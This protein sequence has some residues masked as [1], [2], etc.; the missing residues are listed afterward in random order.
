MGRTREEWLLTSTA[1]Q[2]DER[3][4]F[5]LTHQ[6]ECI[7]PERLRGHLAVHNVQFAGTWRDVIFV[8]MDDVTFTPA[9]LLKSE[10]EGL[11]FRVY[12]KDLKDFHEYRAK[13]AEE[14]DERY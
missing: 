10:V 2:K 8:A 13:L 5:R 4:T 9:E 7:I 1:L 12:Q 6:E 14:Y 11:E 3:F